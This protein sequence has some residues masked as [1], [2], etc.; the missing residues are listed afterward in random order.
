VQLIQELPNVDKCSNYSKQEI[1]NELDVSPEAKKRGRKR[2]AD[3]DD[4]PPKRQRTIATTPGTETKRRGGRRKAA[5][6]T[7]LTDEVPQSPVLATE[8]PSPPYQIY[9]ES[10][11][12]SAASTDEEEEDEDFDQDDSALTI[13]PM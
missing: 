2:K 4:A 5:T 12:M 7:L 10:A 9:S 11:D 3:G 13:V 8:P 6:L 1:D